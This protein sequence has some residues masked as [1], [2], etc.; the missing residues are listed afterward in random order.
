MTIA[1]TGHAN[2]SNF[3]F[4]QN[5]YREVLSLGTQQL[6]IVSQI[7]GLQQGSLDLDCRAQEV[8]HVLSSTQHVQVSATSGNDESSRSHTL[9]RVT[10]ETTRQDEGGAGAE[11]TVSTLCLIDLAGSESAKVWP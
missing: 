7:V 9:I 5:L 8:V 6:C 3:E 11:R 2:L 4:V 10:I 1:P